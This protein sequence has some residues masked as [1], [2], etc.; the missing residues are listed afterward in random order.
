M[1]KIWA[2]GAAVAQFVYTE[3][4]VGSIPTSPTILVF[5][6]PFYSSKC[7]CILYST[8]IRIFSFFSKL[9]QN[10]ALD[11]RYNTIQYPKDTSRNV[12]LNYKIIELISYNS[13]S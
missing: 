6:Y 5:F 7:K 3:K 13:N 9:Y 2:I 1:L 4:V 12:Y 11:F 8:K 10:H